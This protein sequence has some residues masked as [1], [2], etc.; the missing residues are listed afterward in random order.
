MKKNTF[1]LLLFYSVFSFSQNIIYV[2]I[3]AVGTN[4]G[5]SWSNAYNSLSTAISVSNNNDHL[6]VA[7]GIYSPGNNRS[8]SFNIT[9]NI[10]IYG[11]FNGTEA[12]LI[13]RDYKLLLVVFPVFANTLSFIVLVSFPD[14]W[15]FTDVSP[16]T[17]PLHIPTTPVGIPNVV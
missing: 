8:N 11:G 6:W 16:P 15:Y 10:Q 13:D 2:D 1:I 9:K 12:S 5:S 7:E 4:D 17:L 14:P 3:D